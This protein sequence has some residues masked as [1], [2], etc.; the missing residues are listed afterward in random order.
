MTGAE[1]L[2]M[3]RGRLK[4]LRGSVP[5][6]TSWVTTRGHGHTPTMEIVVMVTAVSQYTTNLSIMVYLVF[7]C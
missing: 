3:G 1:L 6:C 5:L 7:Q 2:A 4:D